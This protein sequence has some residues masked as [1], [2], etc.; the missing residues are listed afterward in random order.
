MSAIRMTGLVSGLDT[1]SIVKELMS[2]QRTKST[3]IQNK[4]TKLE[5]KQEKW[6]D[7]NSKIYSFYT[8]QV[9][10][11]RLQGSYNTKKA[12][13]SDTS[14]V[15][16][17]ASSSV[18]EGTHTIKVESVASAQFI[19]GTKVENASGYSAA[20]TELGLDLGS[21]IKVC[22]G[23]KEYTLVV[24]DESD[25]SGNSTNFKVSTIGDFVSALQKAGLNAS[26]DTTQQRFFISSKKSGVDGA[27]EIKSADESSPVN[28]DALG[29]CEIT[30]NNDK[31]VKLPEGAEV[32]KIDASDAVII[33]NNARI[34]GSSN[35]IT[36]NG[37]TVTV[38]GK[39]DDNETVSIGVTRD[40]QAVYDM[41]KG[42]IKSYNEILG[43]LNDAYYA[44][45]A[46][47]YEPL[48]DEQKEAM[49]DE[50]VEKW[51]K[52]IKDSLLRRDSTAG[53]LINTL[54]NTMAGRV[55][56]NGKTY[57][58]SSFGI[59]SVT[60]T[61]KGKLHISGDK[62]DSLSSSEEDKL[63]KA[64]SENPDAVTELFTDIVGK[65]YST[66][67]ED[68]KSTSLSS[69]MSFYNDKEM[70]NLMNDYEDELSDMEDYL[71]KL[72]DRYYHQ[73][74]A[75]ETALSQLNSQSTYLSALLG[76]SNN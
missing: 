4:K 36:V 76:N 19:T 21:S 6:K 11:L 54:R 32:A 10:K 68:L 1:E 74:S 60:Y 27:F 8:D 30:L 7:L 52:K 18:P 29:L 14:K 43:A 69:A 72:E 34:T 42:F 35:T 48:T 55:S 71:V 45:S 20:L 59:S 22:A 13:S 31:T 46:S 70:K 73:F 39:T 37:L 50:Q 5:W 49:T 56:Y 61:E 23:G 57:S 16:V 62:D 47:G 63:M 38:K 64:L 75:M 53:S 9:S 33:Y 15:E 58:L 65:L 41:I 66:M 3:K 67:Q 25:V 2:A 28:L 51:E 24:S 17:S 12:T 26:F 40:T 44:D